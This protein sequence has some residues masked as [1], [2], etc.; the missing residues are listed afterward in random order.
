MSEDGVYKDMSVDACAKRFNE[1]RRRILESI[2]AGRVSASMSGI[3]YYIDDFENLGDRDEHAK[4]MALT[5][6]GQ[7]HI[8][9]PNWKREYDDW[10]LGL[11]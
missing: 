6:N 8:H 10:L 3:E 9:R 5:W 7:K 1:S 11:G 4:E 2:T